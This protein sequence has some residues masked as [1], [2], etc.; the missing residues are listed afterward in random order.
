MIFAAIIEE[1]RSIVESGD[2]GSLAKAASRASQDAYDT[3]HEAKRKSKDVRSQA[4]AQR[5][6]EFASRAHRT[7]REAL[8]T[9]D[10]GHDHHR[11][12][13]KDHDNHYTYHRDAYHAIMRDL[14]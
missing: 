12:L 9:R 7:A 4:V 11:S 8:P 10:P 14:P 13:E 2:Y 1:C 5:A 6:H 3:S